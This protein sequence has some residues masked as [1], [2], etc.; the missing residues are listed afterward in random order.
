MN[1]SEDIIKKLK[2]IFLNSS[3]WVAPEHVSGI[4]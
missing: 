3:S 4:Q 2:Q 1:L